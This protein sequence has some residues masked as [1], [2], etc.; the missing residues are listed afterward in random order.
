MFRSDSRMAI[1]RSSR[2]RRCCTRFRPIIIATPNVALL[3]M[4]PISLSHGQPECVSRFSLRKTA[5]SPDSPT[6]PTSSPS[7]NSRIEMRKTVI[8]VTE[9]LDSLDLRPSGTERGKCRCAPIIFVQINVGKLDV[10]TSTSGG[11]NPGCRGV[12]QDGHASRKRPS[13]ARKQLFGSLMLSEV[14]KLWRPTAAWFAN[15][16]PCRPRE[17]VHLEGVRSMGLWER[18]HAGLQPAKEA[19]RQ[20]GAVP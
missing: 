2:I 18:H 17:P 5:A 8:L 1:V 9:E 7:R 10:L 3:G 14:K 16:D 12:P 6:F 13:T 19:D 20:C 4:P 15:D 11:R